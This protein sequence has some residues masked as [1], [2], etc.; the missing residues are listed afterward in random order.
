MS[1]NRKLGLTPMNTLSTQTDPTKAPTRHTGDRYQLERQKNISSSEPAVLDISE[2]PGYVPPSKRLK[3]SQTSKFTTLSASESHIGSG[4]LLP[5]VEETDILEGY[6]EVIDESG[7]F[8]L[9]DEAIVE[10]V[11]DNELSVYRGRKENMKEEERFLDLNIARDVHVFYFDMHTTCMGIQLHNT[12]SINCRGRSI[13]VLM[14]LWGSKEDKSDAKLI[15][16]SKNVMKTG[17]HVNDMS[18]KD[19]IMDAMKMSYKSTSSITK[20]KRINLLE[21]ALTSLNSTSTLKKRY[22]KSGQVI[23]LPARSVP[24]ESSDSDSSPGRNKISSKTFYGTDKSSP[25]KRVLSDYSYSNLRKSTRV[26]VPG[27]KRAYTLDDTDEELETPK[28]FKPALHYVFCDGSKYSVN[29]QDFKCLYNHDWI[30]DTILDFFLKYYMEESILARRFSEDDIC[31]LSSFF[32]TKLVSN[33]ES[34]Y[35]NVKK[36][37]ANSN[38]MEARYV[39]IP[40]NVNFH[41]FGC[42]ITN[43]REVLRLFR[44]GQLNNWEAE[45]GK[46]W[47]L[48]EEKKSSYP[49]IYILVYDSLRQTHSREVDPIKVF[50]ID[51]VKDKYGFEIP[52]ALIRMKMCTVPQQPNMSDCGVHVILNTR[53]FLEDPKKTIQYWFLKPNHAIVREI[54]LYFEKKKRK[55]AR[56][57]LRDVLWKLQKQ[58]IDIQGNVDEPESYSGDEGNHSD[59]E[60]IEKSDMAPKENNRQSSPQ[61]EISHEANAS[62][63]HALLPTTNVDQ[64][65]TLHASGEGKHFLT[66]SVDASPDATIHTKALDNN[67]IVASIAQNKGKNERRRCL[68]SSPERE[69]LD[70]KESGKDPVIFKVGNTPNDHASASMHTESPSKTNSIYP[71]RIN[72]IGISENNGSTSTITHQRELGNLSGSPATKSTKLSYA[73]LNSGSK[74]PQWQTRRYTDNSSPGTKHLELG[75]NSNEDLVLLGNRVDSA[76]FQKYEVENKSAQVSVQVS[77]HI[78]HAANHRH[79]SSAGVKTPSS[80]DRNEPHEIRSEDTDDYNGPDSILNETVH[81]TSPYRLRGSVRSRKAAKEANPELIEVEDLTTDNYI[82]TPAKRTT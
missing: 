77:P 75:Q 52:R 78:Y 76:R 70:S 16:I 69:P 81:E 51:Y 35:E 61:N 73:G 82:L 30:N 40:I 71:I 19:E 42:I 39:I 34:C 79:S 3:S 38:L 9:V 8:Q 62:N 29:N 7:E 47:T 65:P 14:I 1:R 45:T 15:D 60:I 2:F 21:K 27:P 64:S 44:E 24:I 59:I 10:V 74:T 11:S 37:V 56:K 26:L 17:I 20:H 80:V 5:R 54:N 41:W 4:M 12:V 49:T 31:V 32:Y 55:T 43:L 6:I 68:L 18:S 23:N 28:A 67:H 36:W 48:N 33:L 46:D 66:G 53:K 13:P 50:L 57:D 22:G 58:Q 25:S 63:G 72:S